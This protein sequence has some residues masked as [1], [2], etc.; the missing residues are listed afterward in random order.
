MMVAFTYRDDE[1]D[2]MDIGDEDGD[3]DGS[4]VLTMNPPSSSLANANKRSRIT[5][6]SIGD[7]CAEGPK[8]EGSVD[9]RH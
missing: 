1:V 5:S 8:W 7:D 6:L 3:S 9:E 2:D 4:L